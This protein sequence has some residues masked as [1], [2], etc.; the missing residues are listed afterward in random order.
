M[1]STTPSAGAGVPWELA[2]MDGGGALRRNAII[3]K[4]KLSLIMRI[5]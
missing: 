3:K 5:V 4:G 2:L 1:P